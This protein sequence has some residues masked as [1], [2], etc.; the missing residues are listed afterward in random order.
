MK[1]LTR[2][3]ITSKI[4]I[5][6]GIIGSN[7]GTRLIKSSDSDPYDKSPILENCGIDINGNICETQS[8]N[9]DREESVKIY[10]IEICV[11]GS[12][13]YL[14]Y[15]LFNS[16]EKKHRLSTILGFNTGY[17]ASGNLENESFR[18]VQ[19]KLEGVLSA[20]TVNYSTDESS[21]PF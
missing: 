3:F 14:D 6:L 4:R 19:H 15:A 10:G 1:A 2:L 12:V 13:I 18:S 20:F 7:Y 11:V 9:N 16:G 21:Y 5:D 17:L 8:K